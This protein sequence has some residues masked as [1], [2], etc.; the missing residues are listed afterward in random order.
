MTG[1]AS[2]QNNKTLSALQTYGLLC[3]E[4]DDFL[5]PSRPRITKL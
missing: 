4:K 1:I 3:G 5:A 2:V